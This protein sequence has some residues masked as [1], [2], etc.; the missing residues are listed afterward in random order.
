MSQHLGPI[1]NHIVKCD[2]CS[3]IN[4]PH[5]I[6]D[7]CGNDKLSFVDDLY[8]PIQKVQPSQIKNSDNIFEVFR[9]FTTDV[10]LLLTITIIITII[11]MM[12]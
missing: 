5:T 11:R 12:L 6:C 9:F 7:G 4:K 8:K 10:N 3:K 2:Y 1:I